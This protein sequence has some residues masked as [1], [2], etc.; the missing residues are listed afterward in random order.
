MKKLQTKVT[1]VVS[2]LF[3]LLAWFAIPQSAVAGVSPDESFVDTSNNF[4]ARLSGANSISFQLPLY[5]GW[6]W[7]TD[8][9]I[10]VATMH[11]TVL[12]E[13]GSVAETAPLITWKCT[14]KDID[15]DKNTDRAWIQVKSDFGE[16]DITPGI[17]N[18]F[19]LPWG[20][21]NNIWEKDFTV[22]K[23]PNVTY[24]TIYA[25]WFVPKEI[26]GKKIKF[27]WNVIVEMWG[28]IGFTF[29]V[30]SDVIEVPQ[31]SVPSDPTLS[32]PIISP[33]SK[34]MLMVPW[35]ISSQTVISAVAHYKRSAEDS[36]TVVSGD[37]DQDEVTIPL[38]ANSNGFVPL[39]ATEPH[40]DMY[41]DAS[42]KDYFGYIFANRESEH[43]D[44]PMIHP[45]V[46]FKAT[47]LD[48]GKGSVLLEWKITHNEYPEYYE[49][50]FFEIQRS[51]TG[52]EEDFESLTV[53][54]L[55]LNTTQYS[56][57]D[58]TLLSSSAGT[59]YH[60]RY[61]IRR[62]ITDMWGW[63]G[64]PTVAMTSA[65]L[66]P[67]RLYSPTNAK[68][69]W[70]DETEHKVKVTWEYAQDD[71]SLQVWDDRAELRILVKT[72]NREGKLLDTTEH[73]LTEEEVMKREKVLEF[74]RPCINY[75][76]EIVG[77]AKTSPVT[78]DA[79]AAVTYPDLVIRSIQDWRKLKSLVLNQESDMPLSVALDADIT[80]G[81]DDYIG[82]YSTKN[83]TNNICFRGVFD[84]KGHTITVTDSS[85]FN[86]VKNA[87][88]RN[89]I[90]KGTIKDNQDRAGAGLVMAGD[91]VV[92]ENCRT[93]A[94]FDN[95]TMGAAFVCDP[96]NIS[97]SNSLFAGKV[98]QAK[99]DLSVWTG[100]T[101]VFPQKST[102]EINNCLSAPLS[103]SQILDNSSLQEGCGANLV[104]IYIPD[105]T[106]IFPVVNNSY[107]KG[108]HWTSQPEYNGTELTGTVEEQLALLG[109]GWEACDGWPG[110]TPV[111][112][113]SADGGA[114]QG[115][116]FNVAVTGPASNPTFY[117]QSSGKVEKTLNR[118]IRQSSVV[119]TWTTD[120]GPVDYF[121]VLRRTLGTND[122][123]LPISPK[124]DNTIYEDATVSP[125][126]RYEY[127]V[128]SAVDCEGT[129]YHETDVVVGECKHTG[130]VEGYIRY[131]D[132][133]GVPGIEVSIN[134][135]NN[136]VKTVTT[137]ERGYFMADELSYNG[138][139]AITYEVKP[140]SKDE[141]QLAVD[142]YPV[143]FDKQSNHEELPA[144]VITSVVRFSGYVMYAGTSIPVKGAHFLV[145]GHELRNVNGKP[146]ESDFDGKVSFY[147][148][149]SKTTIQ[150]VMEGHQFTNEG[151][152]KS[153]DGV[154]FTEDIDQVYFYDETRVKLIGRIVGGD[155]QGDL[156]LDNNLS[157][158]NLGTGVKMVLTLEGD[159]SSW[160]VYDN[161]NPE[162]ETRDE[163][164]PHRQNDKNHYKTTVHTT[165][166]RMEVMPDSITGEYTL[167]LPPVR[168][169]V[170][171]VYSDGYPTLFQEGMVSEVIDLT[172]SVVE[173]N[174]VVSGIYKTQDGTPISDPV[175]NYYARYSRIFH[176]PVEL[177]RKQV[178]YDDYDYFGDKSYISRSVGGENVTVPL[179][180]PDSLT[181][182][183]AYTFGYPVFS[184]D[185][186]YMLKLAAVERYYWNNNPANDTVDVVRVGGGK[187]TVQNGLVSGVHKEVVEL[188]DNGEA[189][190][191]LKAKQATYLL[192]GNDALRTV[193]LTLEQDG[194][195][196]EAERIQG[197]VF[198]VFTVPGTKDY[199]SVETPVLLDI[200]RDPPGGGSSATLHKGSTLTNSYSVDMTMKLK[201]KITISYGTSLDNFTGV[202]T[203]PEGSGF[204]YGLI[205][206]GNNSTVFDQEF[207][208]DAE[209]NRTFRYTMNVTEDIRTSSDQT[210]T[211]ANADLYIGMVNNMIVTPAYS[212]RAIPDS[213]FQHIA[214]MQAGGVLPT[215]ETSKYG[216]MVEI[217]KGMDA[218]GNIYHL[219]SDQSVSYGPQVKSRFVHSQKYILEQL[220]PDLVEQCRALMFIGTPEEAQ[221]RANNT[222]MPVYRSLREAT[223]S[224]F[225]APN[226]KNGE[227]YYNNGSEA[228]TDSM[229]YVIYLPQ[230]IE[231][232]FPDRVQ[233][234][235]SSILAWLNMITLNEKEKLSVRNDE[236]LQNYDIDGG[237]SVS[238]SESFSSEYSTSNYMKV[239]GIHGAQYF[240]EKWGDKVLTGYNCVFVPLLATVVKEIFSYSS[241]TLGESGVRDADNNNEN[242]DFKVNFNG[243]SFSFKMVPTFS[244]TTKGVG[245]EGKSYERK[246]SFN[247]SFN[248]KSHLD[249][250]IYRVQSHLD[251]LESV[252]ANDVF[253][254]QNLDEL[255]E[256]SAG[257]IDREYD[258]SYWTYPR[259]FIYRTRGGATAR[260][261]EKGY[262][263][264]MY[265]PGAVID[266]R[267]KQIENPKIQ[268]DKQSVS[269]VAYGEPARFKVYLT[270]E[271][272]QPEAASGGLA[273]YNLYLDETTNPHGAKLYIDGTP[274]NGGG[275]S[276]RLTPGEVT[277][278]TLEVY[279]G[280]EFDYEGIVLGIMSQGDFNIGDNV[281]FDVHFLHEAGGVEISSPGDKWVMNTDAQ[282]DDERGYFLPVVISGF[283]KHQKNFDHIEFQYKETSRGDDFW[284][285][286]CSY[287]ADSTLMA[288]AN[289]VTKMIPEN[290]NIS[291][292]FY[293]EGVVME[294]AYD[295]RAVLFCRDGDKFLTTSSKVLSGIKDTR[296]PQLFGSPEPTNGILNAGESIVFNFSEDIEYNYLRETT[297]FEV[298][299]EVNNDN[300][301][302]SV[303]LRFNGTDGIRTE[304]ER[305]FNGKDVTIDMLIKPEKQN[306][307][308]PLFS[309][310]T[311]GNKLQLWV[312]A[313]KRLKAV[314]NN[315]SFVSTDTIDTSVFT[316]VALV[317][318]QQGEAQETDS[319]K[320]FNGGK[321]IGAFKLGG[322]Y[323]GTGPLIFGSTN[324]NNKFLTKYY[325]GRMMQARV[326][327]RALDGGLIG[328]TYG[329]KNLSGYEM[330]LVDYYPMDEGS[331]NYVT[332]K[333]QGANMLF[334]QG[335][336]WAMPRR[337][338]L[339][340]DFADKGLALKQ[341]AISR[342]SEQDYTL[343]FWFKANTQGRGA[344]I[345]NGSGSADDIGA[346][347]QF[348]I[349]FESKKLL[350]R[351][352]GRTV[353]VP[354]AYYDDDWHHYAMTVNRAM[355][356][357][358]IYVDQT[359][360][361]T[362]E[363]D[364]LGGISGGHPMLGAC[365]YD[366]KVDGQVKT[367]D[368]ANYFQGNLD[369]IYL[370][371]QVLPTTLLQN[372]SKKSPQG[373]EAGLLTY[374][375]FDRR[376]L[377][378]DNTFENV[379]YVYSRKIYK[380][381][382]GN[383]VYE[384][385]SLTN[386]PTT[387]PQRDYLFTDD[388]SVVLAHIDQNLGAPVTLYEE[389]R[390]LNFNFVGR[391]HSLFVNINNSDEKIN[392]R[393][394][395]VTVRE[396]P[397]KNGNVMASAATASFFV[398][399]NPLRW[400]Y[401]NWETYHS[402]GYE[403]YMYNTVQN[404]SQST[405]TYTIENCPKWLTVSP[406]SA[407][408]GP[409]E[410]LNIEMKINKN[411]NPGTYFEIIYLTDEN[412]MA[413][414]LALTVVV[415][416]MEP[417]W[418]V[419]RDLR[420]Q[421]MSITAQVQIGDAIDIDK[422]DIVGVFDMYGGCHGVSRISYDEGTGESLVF[423]TVYDSIH[424]E[425]SSNIPLYFKLWRASTGKEML[426]TPRNDENTHNVT[427][428]FSASDVIGTT[429]KPLLLLGGDQFI[430]TI[431]LEKGW[432]WISFNVISEG[433]RESL[434]KLLSV[435]PWKNGDIITDNNTGATLIYADNQWNISNYEGEIRLSP[436]YSY[437]IKV[438]NDIKAQI[439]GTKIV[440]KPDRTIEVV[441]GWNSIGYT[442]MMNLTVE[443]ALSYYHDMATDGD[444][445]KSHDEF[446]IYTVTNNV[447]RW[448]GNLEYMK[449]GEG[450]MLY[451]KANTTTSFVYPYYEPGTSFFDEVVKAPSDRYHNN[452][453]SSMSLSAV[454]TGIDLEPGDRLV[455]FADGEICGTAT[456]A[457]DDVFYMSIGGEEPRK[458]WFAVEREGDLIAMTPEIMTFGVNAVVGSPN[459]PTRIDFTHCD[460]PR[461]GWYTLDGIRLDSRPVKKGIYIY[462]GKKRVIE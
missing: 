432:N 13:D 381:I 372:Y 377:Q 43:K 313:Q 265:W 246:E 299:G 101:M 190:Y 306:V 133:N 386:Q 140:T 221:T 187:V 442:P 40:Y 45:P 343:M 369:E 370:F 411:L 14:E 97:I 446:A 358:N 197:F 347:N 77:D 301:T 249:F 379:P 404:R 184:L 38:E 361:A 186:T 346:R 220:I 383:I 228:I 394:V 146:L 46:G 310:G 414:P 308:M 63:K 317:L 327:Y 258:I 158:N 52:N 300:V 33:E 225:A 303:S 333:A 328:T 199:L 294:K 79:T 420:Q 380:D 129:D 344:L 257:F 240:D 56:F 430:Q 106:E 72:Y 410:E 143:T 277:Q 89:I 194:T 84:G 366:R 431:A 178:V 459:S 461:Q 254:S 314:V 457:D 236:L 66:L 417:V 250:D 449:P 215:G 70:A 149:K 441:P 416:D 263:S 284:T 76:I 131:P 164:I 15:S 179:A 450:Y 338:S 139:D 180:Y 12:N 147:V 205:N 87:T 174:D 453:R 342:T 59:L 447:G 364:S 201:A 192:Q 212:I 54:M 330:G 182:G 336:A 297:H 224:L 448:R 163:V 162:T 191:G 421:S 119:L 57:K 226:I 349:G 115:S 423:I 451:R 454:T 50:D 387:T 136:L 354:G 434:D 335:L 154:V 189:Y 283:N 298:R 323:A 85:P 73:L 193:T 288:K 403:S 428:T 406:S 251:T 3:T 350:F 145:N 181:G 415:E 100:L 413:E 271:S 412:G 102:I 120:G 36:Q 9:W 400:M 138:Q 435:F 374:L 345:C 405:H 253:T 39:P 49:N 159:N 268:L 176:A 227:F 331:G 375:S 276:I 312:T 455:A 282:Y 244:Y 239:P 443:T 61:R 261:W 397:D 318:Q 242:L 260:P 388:E 125:L 31:G 232:Q 341:K 29:D 19:H 324:D 211:G 20:V 424:N 47:P 262:K 295:L 385:D 203:A 340:L 433:F 108:V 409:T 195:T 112:R 183:V 429:R 132:G 456:Q 127:K 320:L 274:L 32:E 171:Q 223:D 273:F 216:T 363:P 418:E 293:G 65:S 188:D 444:I 7:R 266:E 94:T 86:Y 110:V 81:P 395:Y 292:K 67:L 24:F 172:N 142:S 99:K 389:L 356:V 213:T 304:A 302:E 37:E 185:R 391:D 329:R 167:M 55:D 382:D 204:A 117:Y 355:N 78:F 332:D 243:S 155:E 359:L 307:D 280:E 315:E 95:V 25:N 334:T 373:D 166:K 368:N 90:V 34:G 91:D 371:D 177:M 222:G 286:L 18:P 8:R 135:N 275:R 269:G 270:N 160:L 278:K 235:W 241:N 339:H 26:Q 360:R 321:Q 107:Y 80:L 83:G 2:A 27:T 196:Y 408:V 51:I 419:D 152:F 351:S 148:N 173:H 200:L 462:N 248:S 109:N 438:Q 118:E 309:H 252:P 1:A 153:P 74:I 92:I 245:R 105:I 237:T 384:R 206:T 396:I 58:S 214:G 353:E 393:N 217:A 209:G 440:Q 161:L 121:E 401:K 219:I 130:M 75:K 137:D 289:G 23:R 390:N 392:K 16:Y 348:F 98:I 207:G 113:N 53:V 255:I 279:A 69:D 104:Y 111:M 169:K 230:N 218:A 44:I 150:A 231:K 426:L 82:D 11:Y 281:S 21:N 238:Y 458:L 122:E 402:Y 407:T 41:V 144:F 170:Q 48:D 337:I 210:M 267:T 30:T 88:F 234:H 439:A 422:R 296:R 290:G 365:F 352:N 157:R 229:S 123:F 259:G 233:Q 202:V 319:V 168:W 436:Q 208:M 427:I 22:E 367:F 437:C 93:D 64:N 126:L 445:I 198:N 460:I 272:E 128:R 68:S 42:Y 322:K 175:E 4:T 362:F 28:N 399:R 378:K 35:F 71:N 311:A 17:G 116:T 134:L 316:Q 103:D 6:G 124:L 452:S 96:S 62:M 151:Y 376:E 291:T 114:V 247:I 5:D 287:Y 256:T 264:M 326:W 10:N 165:R 325:T 305:N 425:T 357:V 156:P 285:N 141:L 398:D 60:P